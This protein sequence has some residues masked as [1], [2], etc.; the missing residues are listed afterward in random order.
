MPFEHIIDHG[1]HLVVVKGTGEGSIDETARSAQCL[2]EDKSIGTDYTFMF[3]VDDIALQPTPE[4]V[5]IIA[6]FFDR[7]LSRFSGRM[8][9]VTSKLGLVT[10]AHLIAIAA[11]K[12][13]GRIRVFTS[14]HQ[15]R[16]WL[17]GTTLK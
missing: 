5:W 10:A 9:I 1:D 17:L 11:D 3:V 2:L 8:A 16:Q 13:G 12:M 14:E 6:S 7:M 4:Q 15:A